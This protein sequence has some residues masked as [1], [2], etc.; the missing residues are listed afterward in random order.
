MS[1]RCRRK[2]NWMALASPLEANAFQIIYGILV[3]KTTLR[4]PAVL[5]QTIGTKKRILN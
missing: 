4:V 2:V 3:S 5:S 1:V